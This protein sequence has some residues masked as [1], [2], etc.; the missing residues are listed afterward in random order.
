LSIRIVTGVIV[1]I[2]VVRIIEPI[3]RVIIR[4]GIS[5]KEISAEMIPEPKM[6]VVAEMIVAP[7]KVLSSMSYE[8]AAARL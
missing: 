6:I 8:A 2:I 3:V 5:N 1:I 4:K 7:R